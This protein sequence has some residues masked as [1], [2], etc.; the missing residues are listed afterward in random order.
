VGPRQLIAVVGAVV[1]AGCGVGATAQHQRISAPATPVVD[2]GTEPVHRKQ[3][4]AGPRTAPVPI[5]MYHVVAEAPLG[6]SYSELWVAPDRFA[7]QMGALAHAGYHATTLDAVW[8]AWHGR[9]T[10]PRRPIVVSFDDGYQSQATAARRT[11]ARFGWPGVLNLAV[12][13]VGLK[14]G[15]S[16]REV[17]LMMRDGWEVDAHTLTHVDV[18]TLDAT[19]Q[20][21]EIAGS[22]AWLRHAFGA[23]VDF[24]CYPAG[25]YNAGAEAAVRAA[26]YTGATTTDAGVASDHDDPY[27]L[28]RVRVT[29]T[30][31]GADLLAGLRR[32]RPTTSARPS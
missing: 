8:R 32:L 10:M 17:S 28:P 9:G 18:T 21:E 27:A 23:P 20:R 11:L 2:R 1:L 15:L 30:M 25:R 22:R 24:F 14:G 6:T 26:G 7:Q 5:L 3:V 13:N 16:R 4:P 29:P 19:R 12:M 31:T